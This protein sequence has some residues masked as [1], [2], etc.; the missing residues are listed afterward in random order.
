MLQIPRREIYELLASLDGRVGLYIED[1][2]SGEL[3]TVSPD[4]VHVACSLVKTPMQALFLKDAE[5]GKFPIH[6]KISIPPANRVGGTGMICHLE[7]EVELSWKDVMKLMI[8][9]SDNSATNAIVDLLG[10]ERINLFFRSIGLAA[11][12]MQRKMMDLD[13]IAAGKNN[14]TTAADMGKLMKMIAEGTLVSKKISDSVFETMTGQF[15]TG[16]L[17]ALLPATP[18]CAPQEEK[19]NPKLG[20]VTV[21]NKT[22]GLPK[23]E[24]DTG[25]FIL[26]GGKKYLI[27]MLTS[28]LASEKEGTA[29][30]AKVSRV[31]YEALSG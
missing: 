1:L 28:Q 15:Y 8:I 29:C 19:W 13:A 4:E 17:S 21:A 23:T 24:H 6:E 31:V 25:I 14:Y 11:T 7:P 20:T 22:G 18:S 10:L 12:E 9:V 30:I 16:K 2:E 26:P 3:F 27:A 5:E